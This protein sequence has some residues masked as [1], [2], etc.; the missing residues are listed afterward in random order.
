MR[1]SKVNVGQSHGIENVAP[2]QQVERSDVTSQSKCDVRIGC[3]G[4]NVR[5]VALADIIER[6]GRCLLF[7]R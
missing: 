5:N 6:F 7:L 2:P 3:C 4:S 1:V